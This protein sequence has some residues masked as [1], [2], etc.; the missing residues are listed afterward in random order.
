MSP[1]YL[2]DDEHGNTLSNAD[3]KGIV[4]RLSQLDYNTFPDEIHKDGEIYIL[5]E[6]GGRGNK[7]ESGENLGLYIPQDFERCLKLGSMRLT[8]KEAKKLAV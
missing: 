6:I 2:V 8:S 1:P 7:R 3:V 4:E 5:S